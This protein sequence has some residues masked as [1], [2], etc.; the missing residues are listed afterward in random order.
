MKRK[1]VFIIKMIASC[2]D[3]ICIHFSGNDGEGQLFFFFFFF[4]FSP[5][6]LICREANGIK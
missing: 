6:E 4:L 1:C 2:A 5:L 3:V